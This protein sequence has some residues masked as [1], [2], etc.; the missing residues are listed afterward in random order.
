[1]TTLED[2]AQKAGVSYS[3]VSRTLADSPLVNAKT[4]ERIQRLVAEYGY[5]VYQIARSLATR[6]TLTLGLVCR[7][8]SIHSSPAHRRY[9]PQRSCRW[10]LPPTELKRVRS[11]RRG[12]VHQCP[13]RTEGGWDYW[14]WEA[15]TS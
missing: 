1:M 3:T 13:L 10:L 15:A 14:D 7:R 2:I 8:P 6:S 5:R 12:A 4:K 9:C 11:K